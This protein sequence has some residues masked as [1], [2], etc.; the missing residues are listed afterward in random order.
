MRTFLHPLIV[1]L[2]LVSL[3]GL[4]ACR[5][6]RTA[7]PQPLKIIGTSDN[8]AARTKQL[9]NRQI[10][11]SADAAPPAQ[12]LDP[13]QGQLLAAQMARQA[14]RREL[15]RKIEN[16]EV[17]PGVKVAEI[18][19]TDSDKRAKVEELLRQAQQKGMIKGEG[20]RCTVFVSVDVRQLDRVLGQGGML[21][22][23][24]ASTEPLTRETFR[25]RREQEALDD[26]RARA[27]QLAQNLPVNPKETVGDRMKKS[28]AVDDAVRA[29]IASLEPAARVFREDGTCE[30]T[31]V[32]DTTEIQAIARRGFFDGWK[33][34]A[35][36]RKEK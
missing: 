18:L 4:S 12:V 36:R 30:V 14:A 5:L 34:F 6:Q 32:M 19:R 31:L 15:A 24:M 22:E 29:A 11:A 9:D 2:L 17:R 28:K 1:A 3:G 23:A 16:I 7:P 35:A 25:R 10:S 8:P 21:A 20:G 33:L 27:L 26:A 13:I